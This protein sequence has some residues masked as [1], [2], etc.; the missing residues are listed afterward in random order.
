[1]GADGSVLSRALSTLSCEGLEARRQ[2]VGV[3]R[4]E[5]AWGASWAIRNRVRVRVRVRVRTSRVTPV[6]G[7]P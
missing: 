2:V 4:G 6:L 5:R 1:M 7:S 3:E